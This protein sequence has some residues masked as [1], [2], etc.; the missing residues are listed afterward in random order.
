[1]RLFT[2]G[3]V[4]LACLTMFHESGPAAAAEAIRV[5][6]FNIRYGTADDGVN[7]WPKRKQFLIDTISA[8]DPDLLGTQ[9][10]LAFQRDELL[11]V[12]EEVDRRELRRVVQAH[13]AVRLERR[14]HE[15]L[16][17][18]LRLGRLG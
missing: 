15:L 2:V 5:M 6:S 4:V 14:A 10:T 11:G 16:D 12:V 7:A 8:F 9:E 18:R 1:M 13:V 3:A 17:G